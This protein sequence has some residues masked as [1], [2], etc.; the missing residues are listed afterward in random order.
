MR[1]RVK[2]KKVGERRMG[3][4]GRGGAKKTRGKLGGAGRTSSMDRVEK[5]ARLEMK[6]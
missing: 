6:R 2:G 3:G 1:G 5:E 4:A